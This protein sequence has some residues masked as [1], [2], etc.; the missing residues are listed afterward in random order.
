M[1]QNEKLSDSGLRHTYDSGAMK[2]P[3]GS[4]GR[5]ELIS[6]FSIM[7]LAKHYQAGAEKYKSRNWEQGIPF[8]RCTGS[9]ERH[10]Q[11]WKMGKTD[12]DHLAAI[13]FWAFAIM[14]YQEL[15]MD[16][17]DDMPQYNNDNK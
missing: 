11:Q 10:L 3:V 7:R 8:E 12:E 2:E 16:Y 14:H 17:L 13:A 4:R 6:P 15:G 1:M 5:P 9:L